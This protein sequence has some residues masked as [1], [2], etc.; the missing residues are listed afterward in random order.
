MLPPWV[1]RSCRPSSQGRL[2]CLR[3]C[4]RSLRSSCRGCGPSASPRPPRV[5]GFWN[6]GVLRGG[7]LVL[8][9]VHV[10]LGGLLVLLRLLV[11]VPLRRLPRDDHL[12]A[13]RLAP[14]L[15]LLLVIQHELHVRAGHV[16]N[17]ELQISPLGQMSPA[18]GSL[19][20]LGTQLGKRQLIR[21]ADHERAPEEGGAACR[22]GPASDRV[23]HVIYGLDHFLPTPTF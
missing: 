15:R 11:R 19:Q 12:E 17:V 4:P 22:G 20:P 14:K 16:D 13:P 3:R 21:W 6:L 2:A 10:G 8:Q 1:W 9:S 18:L 23:V 5:L 7:Q